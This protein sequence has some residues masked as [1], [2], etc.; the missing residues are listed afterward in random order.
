MRVPRKDGSGPNAKV[1]GYAS[2]FDNYVGVTLHRGQFAYAKA[3]FKDA[4]LE[5]RENFRVF[6]ADAARPDSWNEDLKEAMSTLQAESKFRP[7]PDTNATLK[8]EIWILALDCLYHFKPSRFPILKYAAKELKA[9]I[10][11]F[12]LML[13]D[14]IS[15]WDHILLNIV[16]WLMGC[17]QDAFM[18]LPEY[19]SEFHVA[20]YRLDHVEVFDMSEHVFA[21]LAKFLRRREQELKAIGAGLGKLKAAMWLFEWWASRPV[22]KGAI[23]VAKHHERSFD[24]P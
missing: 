1:T 9:N 10:M 15:I 20:G 21:P 11:A 12:D 19:R 4:E 8:N 14:D 23:V 24:P 6:C 17:P 3:R 2:M 7:D 18:N 16:R 22:I 5:G 13:D